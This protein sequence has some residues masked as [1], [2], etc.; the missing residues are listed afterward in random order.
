MRRQPTA[1]SL[2]SPS[3]VKSAPFVVAGVR[4]ELKDKF[5]I[6][7]RQIRVFSSRS[8]L[9]G[10]YRSHSDGTCL[11]KMCSKVGDVLNSPDKRQFPPRILRGKHN[12]LERVTLM[13][14]REVKDNI[15]H[16]ALRYPG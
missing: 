12:L 1:R 6:L 16:H 10:C 4:Q 15:S 3:S 2:D 8:Q 7:L 5:H 11:L 9:G 14:E 13:A